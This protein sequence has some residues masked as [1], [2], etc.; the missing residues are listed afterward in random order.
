MATGGLL[1][2]VGLAIGLLTT[3]SQSLIEPVFN[4]SRRAPKNK[5]LS[6]VH[7]EIIRARDFDHFYL[8]VCHDSLHS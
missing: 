8:A 2:F 5:F 7:L 4:Y 1:S 3:A 6:F